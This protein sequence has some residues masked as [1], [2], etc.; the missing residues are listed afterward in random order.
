M[1]SS[2]LVCAFI[3]PALPPELEY[4]IVELALRN[5]SPDS[6]TRTALSTVARRFS[7]WVDE[8][9]D[10]VVHE[11]ILID[12]SHTAN[13]FLENVKGGTLH[14]K[15]VKFLCITYGVPSET[16]ASI[17]EMCTEVKALAMWAICREST[18][19]F[20]ALSH[21]HLSLLSIE[22]SQLKL[23]PP[24]SNWLQVRRLD[25]VLFQDPE[26]HEF[27]SA[28]GRLPA[29]THLCFLM[30]QATEAHIVG[31][32][33]A[34]PTLQVVVVLVHTQYEWR[35][36]FAIDERVVVLPNVNGVLKEWHAKVD[37]EQNVWTTAEEVIAE[38]RKAP[39]AFSNST[40]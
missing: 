29:L 28:L 25:L 16:A 23:L 40:P 15:V 33:D 38:R 8:V 37:G 1:P 2:N 12:S 39:E 20:A 34:C 17:A 31:V 24:V 26:V 14:P 27:V 30:D 22:L 6:A 5:K 19:L 9:W 21:L 35:L 18:T 13:S 3:M 4:L 10:E 36:P 11:T 32:L 7:I